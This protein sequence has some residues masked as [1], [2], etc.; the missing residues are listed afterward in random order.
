MPASTPLSV[1]FTPTDMCDYNS[2]TNTV[3]LLVQPA[4]LSVTANNASRNFGQNN[5]AFTG[6]LTGVTNGDNITA[7]Y[8][9]SAATNSPPGTYLIIP[10]LV[11]PNQRATNYTVTLNNGTLT[12]QPVADVA[13]FLTAPT[14][15]YAGS[16]LVYTITVTNLGPNDSSNVVV[17][18]NLPGVV[19]TFVSTTG[20]GTN[21]G[22]VV[23]WPIIPDLTNGGA[24]TFTLTV[25]APGSGSF[26]DAASST[27]PTFD[28]NL[29]NNNGSSATPQ[30]TTLVVP[31]PIADIAVFNVGPSTVTIEPEC[32]LRHYGDEHGPGNFHRCHAQR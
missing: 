26:T 7:T 16:N 24:I 28:P 3:T 27:S 15:V 31:P 8:A 9:S 1:V 19:V 14:T 12:V 2:A 22:G 17:S 4:P 30:V 13:I 11:D 32:D 10:T 21:N 6:T 18:D 29:S 20:G 23:T 25:H 5:P